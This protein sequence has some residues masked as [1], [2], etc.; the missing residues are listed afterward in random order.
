MPTS[1]LLSGSKFLGKDRYDH[2]LN[3]LLTE[4][5]I[6]GQKLSNAQLKEGFKKR[7][8]KIDFEKFVHKVTSTKASVGGRGPGSGALVK[9][10]TG[11]IQKYVQI[12]TSA[13]KQE[14]GS[15]SG[16]LKDIIGSLGNIIKTLN[17]GVTADIK[18]QEKKRKDKERSKREGIEKG[19]EKG[20]SAVK[21]V[22]DKVLAPVKSILSR[23]FDFFVKMIL[24]RTI[25]KLIDW[26][27]DPKNQGKVKS[28]IRFFSDN[29]VKLLS[30]YIVFGTSFG[31]FARGLIS[32]VIRSTIRLGAAIAGLAARAGISK[33]GK[34]ASF[35][36]G[37]RGKVL[38]TALEVGATVA[39]T[40]ALNKTLEGGEQKTQGFAG[41]GYVIPRIPTFSGGGFNFKGMLGGIFNSAK[42][43]ATPSGFV[44]GP[45][46]PK[47]DKVPALLS[48]GEFVVSAGAVQKYGVDTFEAMNAAGGGTNKPK[49]VNG[50]TYAAGGGYIGGTGGPYAGSGSVEEL[51]ERINNFFKGRGAGPNFD[52]GNP[53]T[54]RSGGGGG[55][56]ASGGG[57]SGGFLS[58]M[59]YFGRAAQQV[60]KIIGSGVGYAQNVA[61]E[62]LKLA[63]P[64]LS[65][66]QRLPGE[67]QKLAAPA[68]S[69]AQQIYGGVKQKV[70]STIDSIR[71]FDF[72]GLK[73]LGS[74]IHGAAT[75]AAPALLA[76]TLG[77]SRTDKSISQDMQR[78][79][80]EAQKNAAKRGQK[81]VD[82][83]DYA[84]GG[85]SAAGLT[86]GRIG[87][88]EFKRDEKGRI[89]GIRQVYDTNRSAREAMQQAGESF[90]AFKK[91][92][93]RDMGSLGR[94]AYKPFEALLAKVQ[95]RGMTMHDVNFD[96]KVLGFKPGK[97][98]LNPTQ[99]R[100]I[101]EQKN[102]E[103]LQNKRPWWDKMGLFGGA[104]AE[105]EREKKKKL[106]NAKYYG[107]GGDPSGS[108]RGQAQRA[109]VQR[110]KPKTSA[111]PPPP[112]PKTTVVSAPK[113]KN[114]RGGGTTTSN[115]KPPAVTANNNKRQSNAKSSYGIKK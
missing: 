85:L 58:G 102:R 97:E 86:M 52:I 45:G 93:F 48:N 68:M 20:F 44:S 49:V 31:K 89:I 47:D 110:S 108:G 29:W 92:G 57:G 62:A 12:Q 107:P 41:G 75:E 112:K 42:P 100:M 23:I 5:T 91:S 51:K 38:G 54:W 90:D 71:N 8:N 22:I 40:I 15:I 105:M 10:P 77:I 1:K 72:S 53:S 78:A 65:T 25:V 99:K 81:N 24:A 61:G 9:S 88:D 59:G 73:T 28:L 17:A 98:V 63:A 2:Y 27:A 87:N 109:N 95:N 115:T 113:N 69:K 111:P 7:N 36:G 106:E 82:Y 66:L 50:T 13:G 43:Q 16:Y 3:E 56:S 83:G 76:S 39:G 46:G 21:K 103:A 18:N 67:A 11:A 19:L 33:F 64:S 4:K 32:L 34:V 70:G 79:I 37:R 80:L 30:L 6:G 114:K 35:L 55:T 101:S 84:G 94:A 60:P 26:L 104:T 74:N 14:V 96:E